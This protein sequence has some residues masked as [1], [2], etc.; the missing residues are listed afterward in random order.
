MD[1]TKTH[2]N[3]VQSCRRTDGQTLDEWTDGH[4]FVKRIKGQRY[5][6]GPPVKNKTDRYTG[7]AHDI[8]NISQQSSV[9][10]EYYEHF[11]YPKQSYKG[12]GPVK[13]IDNF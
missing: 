12:V 11:F 5:R 8:F 6:H 3:F 1:I 2:V 10:L 13:P 4:A 7:A 9:A